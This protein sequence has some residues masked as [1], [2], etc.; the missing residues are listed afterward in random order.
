MFR[1]TRPCLV[2]LSQ[3]SAMELNVQLILENKS[4]RQEQKLKTLTKYVRRYPSGWKKRL[5]LANLLYEKGSWEEAIKEYYQI[6]ERQPQLINVR[7]KLAKILQVIERKT[8]AIAIYQKTLPLCCNLATK[9]HIRGLI[10]V[11]KSQPQQAIQDFKLAIV[12]EPENPAHWLVLG[13]V[14]LETKNAMA[15]LSAF[16]QILLL[17]PEDLIALI[18]SY[19]ALLALGKFPEAKARLNRAEELAP[20]DYTVLKRRLAERLKSKLVLNEEGKKTKKMITALLKIAPHSADAYQLKA[21]YYL[22]RGEKA[23]TIAIWQ[24]FTQ[25]YPH[26]PQGWN[27]YAQ[28]LSTD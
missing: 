18:H 7:L 3:P 24:Q 23:K 13:Q 10:A 14:Y 22:L 17:K 20:H 25:K 1:N 16:E 21:D 6:I 19:D 2:K 5:E 15:A 8:E 27:Y 9:H 28:F 26:N 12:S 11:C 4:T